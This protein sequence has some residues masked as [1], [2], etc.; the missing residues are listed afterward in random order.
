MSCPKRDHG[1]ERDGGE[2][3]CR[4]LVVARGDGP[5]KPRHRSKPPAGTFS[6]THC[7]LVGARKCV[8]PPNPNE[9]SR[10]PAPIDPGGV[11]ASAVRNETPSG[12]I[13]PIYGGREAGIVASRAYEYR[14]RAQQC[15]EMARSFEDRNARATLSHMAQAWQRLADMAAPERKRPVQQQQQQQQTQ[16]EGD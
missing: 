14:R 3:V 5:A 8:L 2:E 12:R 11:L 6:A 13:Q 4:K 9:G 7:F 16:P 1:C 15:L 10:N